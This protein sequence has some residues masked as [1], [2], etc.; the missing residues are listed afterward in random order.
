MTYKEADKRAKQFVKRY[1]AKKLFALDRATLL[2]DAY[3]RG[4]LAGQRRTA[5]TKAI[6]LKIQ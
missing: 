2:R 1:P 5:V 6:R 4:L 3:C